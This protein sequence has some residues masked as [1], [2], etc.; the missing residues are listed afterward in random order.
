MAVTP[1]ASSGVPQHTTPSSAPGNLT[2]VTVVAG[3]SSYYVLSATYEDTGSILTSTSPNGTTTISYDPT[4]TYATNTLFPT[5]SSG[6]VMTVGQSYDAT[7]TGL[8]LMS[9]DQNGQNT[10]IQTYD[11]M[12]RP[13]EIT[14][15][16]GGEAQ[17]HYSPTQTGTYAY[18]SSGVFADTEVQDAGYGRQSRVAVMNE[19]GGSSWYQHDY[20]YDANGNLFFTSYSY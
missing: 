17:P 12:L 7:N 6:V 19:P 3:T 14:Y 9:T 15:P 2:S 11:S 8:P 16:D 18:Q 10:T 4:F 5:P 20:C 1:K 13:T